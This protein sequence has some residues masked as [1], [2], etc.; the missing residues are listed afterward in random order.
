[1]LDIPLQGLP[2]FLRTERLKPVHLCWR[3]VREDRWVQVQHVLVQHSG[4]GRC[5]GGL[6]LRRER[7]NDNGHREPR[8]A[9]RA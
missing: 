1:M 2:R 7:A 3:E 8:K 6:R 5:G 4:C 9:V